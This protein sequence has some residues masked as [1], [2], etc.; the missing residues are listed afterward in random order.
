M[1][2]KLIVLTLLGSGAANAAQTAS[3]DPQALFEAAFWSATMP[4]TVGDDAIEGPGADFLIARASEADLVMMGEQHATADIANF[5][6]LFYGQIADL[7][8]GAY[9]AE[10][11]PWSAEAAEDLLDIGL[12]EF[13]ED[14]RHRAGGLG[15]PFLFFHEDAA[16]AHAIV[17]HPAA[18]ET[19]LWGVDQVFIAAG[20]LLVEW[21]EARAQTDAQIAAIHAFAA[22]LGE[23]PMAIGSQPADILDDLELAFEDQADVSELLAAMRLS[24]AIYAPFT[25][26]GGS[27]YTANHARESWMRDRFLAHVERAIAEDD[28]PERL[29][30]KFGGNHAMR[31][32][33]PTHVMGFGG[34][35]EEWGRIRGRDFFNF[36]VE[37]RGGDM[38]NPQSGAA[39][40]CASYFI[41]PE[42]WL[43][44]L[45]P[46]GPVVV[47]LRAMRPAA[48]A[49]R[50]QLDT[51][52]FDAIFAFDVLVVLPDVQAAR[53]V[54]Q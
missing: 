25:G 20:D 44:Q 42:S 7:G 9:V 10:I 51:T 30:F 34:F 38:S 16:L 40:D 17:T 26:R 43:A 41:D 47:D 27:I 19:A 11:D 15:Y 35:I 54:S 50:S 28:L 46:D 21:I 31:G 8:F 13:I 36:M 6:R 39:T 24:N 1:F 32:R 37:C 23:D 29:F 3:I 49:A 52:A 33:T 53:L 45:L 22:A 2:R 12:S 48:I 14:A 4:I 5:G 18:A